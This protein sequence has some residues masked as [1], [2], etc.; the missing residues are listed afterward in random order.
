MAYKR[1]T[2]YLNH[3]H[4]VVLRSFRSVKTPRRTSNFSIPFP[5]FLYAESNIIVWLTNIQY[6]RKNDGEKVHYDRFLVNIDTPTRNS[7]LQSVNP[8]PALPIGAYFQHIHTALVHT[9]HPFLTVTPSPLGGRE[10]KLHSKS[11]FRRPWRWKRRK[12]PEDGDCWLVRVYLCHSSY[13]L[14]S[15]DIQPAV[16]VSSNPNLGWVSP[17]AFDP[18]RLTCRIIRLDNRP[19]FQFWPKSFIPG[20]GLPSVYLACKLLPDDDIFGNIFTILF[21]QFHH[22]DLVRRVWTLMWETSHNS[23]Q[24]RNLDN[25]LPTEQA[26]C[27]LKKHDCGMCMPAHAVQGHWNGSPQIESLMI[28]RS[29]ESVTDFW[30]RA[31]ARS[32]IVVS[33]IWPQTG[34]F[35]ANSLVF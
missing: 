29:A 26:S 31:F 32:S 30:Q 21:K 24:E 16:F 3:W 33:S 28:L 14:H 7:R 4:Q 8:T 13:H 12:L 6:P 1:E 25:E 34:A 5:R 22:R 10:N 27:E 35:W 11:S 18:S 17:G 20:G 19:L 23:I 2:I 9:P 15:P